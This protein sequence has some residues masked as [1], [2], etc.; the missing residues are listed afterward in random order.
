MAFAV[1]ACNG[2]GPFP[3]FRERSISGDRDGETG[4]LPQARLRT[5]S[6]SSKRT[7]R[8]TICSWDTRERRPRTT[9]TTPRAIR[10][11]CT[12]RISRSLGISI[13]SSS[14]FFAACD[15]HNGKLPGTHCKMDG[16]NNELAGVWGSQERPV[17]LR[18]RER[19]RAVL[20]DGKAVR[21]GR[22]RC[23]LRTSTPASSRTSTSSLPMRAGRSIPRYGP[24]GCE[25][26]AGGH[27][28]DADG[29]AHVRSEHPSRALA[30][31]R[32]EAKRTP[33]A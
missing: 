13:T 20:E 25:G 21:A 33:P 24:W 7:A 32:S 19:D 10:S 17:R 9:A 23:L 5:S 2:N 6:S 16:W 4:L 14:A 12:L 1:A 30:T 3:T 29:R 26:D 27:D 31:R 18:P 28:S 8:L 11:R 15:A 22:Q